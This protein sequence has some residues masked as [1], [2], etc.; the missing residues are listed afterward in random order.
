MVD[1]IGG[2]FLP[3]SWVFEPVG[4]NFKIIFYKPV[5]K[6]SYNYLIQDLIFKWAAVFKLLPVKL[7]MKKI[8]MYITVRES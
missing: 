5:D 3:V 1:K 8:V 6:T 2:K 7:L 4:F